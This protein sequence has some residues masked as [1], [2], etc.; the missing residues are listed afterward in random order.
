MNAISAQ[1]ETFWAKDTIRIHP[2]ITNGQGCGQR[3]AGRGDDED[4]CPRRLARGDRRR[5]PKGRPAS[6]RRSDG[7]GAEVEIR[8][9]LGYLVQRDDKRIGR[10]FG[11]NLEA[12]FRSGEF[13]IG[14]RRTGSTDMGDLA[15]MMP[16]IDRYIA[17]AEDSADWRINEPE[18]GYL[19]PAKLLAM[20]SIGLLY[21]D[22]RRRRR[23]SQTSSRQ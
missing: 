10:I 21:E 7:S 14:E 22:P 12:L 9:I 1:G 3:G 15:H 5:Q 20:T 17:T 6:A 11:G 2:I 19:T 16:V 8:T 13:S 18:H 23:S 4:F